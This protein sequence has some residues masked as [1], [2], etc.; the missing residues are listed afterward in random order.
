MCVPQLYI[1]APHVCE[2]SGSQKR[3]S[4]PLELELQRLGTALGTLGTEPRSSAKSRKYSYLLP[5]FQPFFETLNQIHFKRVSLK[6]SSVISESDMDSSPCCCFYFGP[7]F[8]C[9][10][11]LFWGGVSLDSPSCP[12]IPS[13]PV[14]TPGLP[15]TQRAPP[16]SAFPVLRPGSNASVYFCQ[17]PAVYTSAY[18]PIVSG[19]QRDSGVWSR[20][21]LLPVL[22]F[23]LLSL[24]FWIRVVLEQHLGWKV[25]LIC[26][27][28]LS[29]DC[30]LIPAVS[31]VTTMFLPLLPISSFSP[32]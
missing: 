12:G 31:A 3:A 28:T 24:S 21:P 30:S 13:C 4:N 20:L 1:C 2:S 16:T 18:F 15:H 29:P 11:F 26:F 32:Q 25:A 14:C 19:L 5:S 23:H 22:Y 27:C 7:F 9:L 8:D 17:N 10:L 6:Y